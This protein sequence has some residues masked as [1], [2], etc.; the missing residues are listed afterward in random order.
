MNVVIV[1]DGKVGY[2]LAE[3]LSA[4]KHDVT[5]VDR[6]LSALQKASDSL[7]VMTVRGNGANVKTLIEAG[8]EKAEILIAVTTND[9]TNMVCC[10]MS[11]QLGATYTIARIRD[12]EYTES[13]NLL[14]QG[15]GI[16]MVINP[17]RA[18]ALEISRILRFPSAINIEPFA[19]GRVE[20]VEFR[21]EPQDALAGHSVREL[22]R[23]YPKVLYCA[24]ERDG[25][26][27]I[28][29]GDFI[30]RAMDKLHVAG[31]LATITQFFKQLDK[32]TQRVKSAMLIGGGHIAYYLARSIAGMGI[33]L[34]IIEINKQKCEQLSE[35]LDDVEIIY[36]DGTDQDVL[37]S[38]NLDKMESLICLTDRDEENLM[39]GLYGVHLGVPKVIVKVNRLNYLD[40]I[41]GM[42]IDCVVSPKRTIAWQILRTVRALSHSKDSSV[43][44]KLYRI[45]GGEIDALEFTAAAGAPY[46]NKPLKELKLK[47]GCLIAAIVHGR[48]VVIPFGEDRIQAGDT[49]LMVVKTRRVSELN[50]LLN[51]E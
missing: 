21:V 48:K 35:D 5:L 3:Y 49:V 15:M 45:V 39:T 30:V 27:H 26:A 47:P 23:R 14:Q 7:D 24:V 29:T 41:D 20:V 16:D 38:E 28:P 22:N 12:P 9:E 19:Q 2:T 10:L 37:E 33:S 31:D 40:L 43:I 18:A 13:L 51:M 50:E 42:G 32:E 1:G 8:V 44:E 36:G 46:L 25:A 4:E 11:K 17:E 6:N 34:K